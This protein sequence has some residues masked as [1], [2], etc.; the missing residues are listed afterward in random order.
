MSFNLRNRSFLTLRDFT[1][2]EIDFLPNLACELKAAKIGRMK[3][4]A[5]LMKGKAGTQVVSDRSGLVYR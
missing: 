2:S 3:D 4:A 1:P 5:R